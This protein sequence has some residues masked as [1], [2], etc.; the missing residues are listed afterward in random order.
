MVPFNRSATVASN[1]L[2]SSRRDSNQTVRSKGVLVAVRDAYHSG[3]ASA[4]YTAAAVKAETG[5]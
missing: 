1:A 5:S 2:N 3:Q 4:Q